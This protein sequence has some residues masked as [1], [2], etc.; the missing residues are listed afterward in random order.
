MRKMPSAINGM[1]GPH[2]SS[3]VR[4]SMHNK[5]VKPLPNVRNS[6]P[7]LDND[8][9]K[10]DSLDID[11]NDVKQ[12]RIME[13]GSLKGQSLGRGYGR[14]NNRIGSNGLGSNQDLKRAGPGFDGQRFSNQYRSNNNLT[15]I[16]NPYSGFKQY[17][18][19]QSMPN[20]N[21]DV[22]MSRQRNTKISADYQHFNTREDLPT[23]A[24]Q[25]VK[26]Y[27]SQ[28]QG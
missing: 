20:L 12:A 16:Q 4:T 1:K 26:G 5:S 11:Y 27:N 10:Y 22:P 24:S 15:G 7:Y 9:L 28:M 25:I 3:T 17:G 6:Q 14:N 23:S 19:M 13:A 18:N 21:T 2:V 8:K